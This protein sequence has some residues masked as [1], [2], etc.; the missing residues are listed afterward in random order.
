MAVILVRF[1]SEL[2]SGSKG[3]GGVKRWWPE[4]VFSGGC[5]GKKRECARER[6]RGERENAAESEGESVLGF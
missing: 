6:G 4:P 3:G 5:R 2:G 1:G